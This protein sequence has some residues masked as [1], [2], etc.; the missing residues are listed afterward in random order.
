L[1]LVTFTEMLKQASSCSND[2]PTTAVG[3]VLTM[4]F[5]VRSKPI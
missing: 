1:C 4:S 5:P 2:V 3:T